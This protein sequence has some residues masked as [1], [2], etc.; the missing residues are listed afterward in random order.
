[1]KYDLNDNKQLL[2]VF[3]KIFQDSEIN[4]YAP[5]IMRYFVI[6][7]NYALINLEDNINRL[8]AGDDFKTVALEA[9]KAGFQQDGIHYD[10]MSLLTFLITNYHN[11]GF[12][13]HSYPAVYTA[14]IHQNGLLATNRNNDNNIFYRIAEKYQ[15]GDYFMKSNNRICVTGKLDNFS[16]KQYAIYTPEWLEQFLKMSNYEGDINEAIER[17][18]IEELSMI[19]RGSLMYYHDYMK[20]NPEYNNKDYRD[21][22]IY[23]LNT[24]EQRFRYGN[25]HI[26]IAFIPKKNVSDY[27]NFKEIDPA[28]IIPI[29]E[30]QN[31]NDQQ[32]F[33]VVTEMLA[34]NEVT[35]NRD[36]PSSL[37]SLI[38]YD[39]PSKEEQKVA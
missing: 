36:I 38:T 18:N 15:F 14:N 21:L 33:D 29:I 13:Y 9:I 34:E 16:T 30:E 23:I 11:N 2:Q 17:G 5:I 28:T 24:I 8:I 22:E 20:T 1:M 37:F 39:I 25:N 35:T 12:Y 32:V 19:A 27:F 7:R 26:G 4:L 3:G 6:T 10:N 31:L